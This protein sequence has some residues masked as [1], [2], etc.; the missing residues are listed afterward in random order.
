ML[1]SLSGVREA[2]GLAS[3]ERGSEEE[4]EEL[5][6]EEE[7]E[8]EEEGELPTVAEPEGELDEE[9]LDLRNSAWTHARL[10]D[11]AQRTLHGRDPFCGGLLRPEDALPTSVREELP[12]RK[13]GRPQ[14]PRGRTLLEAVATEKP[15]SFLCTL[16][17]ALAS[18]LPGEQLAALR[19]PLVGGVEA[20][21]ERLLHIVAATGGYQRVAELRQWSAV[22]DRVSG[23]SSLNARGLQHRQAYESLLLAYEA[24]LASTGAYAALVASC[25]AQHGAPASQRRASQK[26]R[27]AAAKRA[28]QPPPAPAAAPADDLREP[29]H[30]CGVADAA[31]VAARRCDYCER[32]FCL[33]CGYRL[34]TGEAL[35]ELKYLK[36][37]SCAV[38]DPNHD[39]CQLCREEGDLLCCDSCPR[40]FHAACLGLR[41]PLADGELACSH[42]TAAAA[43]AEAGGGAGPS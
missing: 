8:E 5:T 12:P 42:C 1:L 25:R 34:G 19:L 21:A 27:G 9:E 2:L 28:A 43:A 23:P 40:A 18:L 16:A 38:G 6:F 22:A 41:E 39:W 35:D 24:H 10:M 29:C 14:G 11:A 13:V 20:N 33:A 30:T 37:V 4:A 31:G 7:E 36:C 15:D 26:G 32:T 3:P 17:S